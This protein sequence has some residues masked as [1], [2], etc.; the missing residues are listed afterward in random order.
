MVILLEFGKFVRK[1]GMNFH[2]KKFA[3][4]Y[5]TKRMVWVKR[6]ASDKQ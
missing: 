5:C 1:N 6:V 4:E 2:E 3:C